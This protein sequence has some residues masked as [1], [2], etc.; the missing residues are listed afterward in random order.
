MPFSGFVLV[1]VFCSSSRNMYPTPPPAHA[2][3][4]VSDLPRLLPRHVSV[5]LMFAVYVM[6][7]FGKG[8]Y[9]SLVATT[10]AA[11]E[12][13]AVYLGSELW[14]AGGCNEPQ[15]VG[16]VWPGLPLFGRARICEYSCC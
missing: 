16:M 13:C 10:A 11:P 12:S 4:L 9:A 8:F 14:G 15:A 3:P 6:S 1:V 7:T 5:Y 2:T